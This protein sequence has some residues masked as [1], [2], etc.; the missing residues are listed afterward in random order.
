[1][2]G[3]SLKTSYKEDIRDADGIV[4]TVIQFLIDTLEEEVRLTVPHLIQFIECL[5]HFREIRLEPGIKK[6]V[7]I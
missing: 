1:M 7:L 4:I 6:R 5:K 3:L 2:I